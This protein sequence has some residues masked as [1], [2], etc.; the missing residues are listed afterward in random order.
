MPTQPR[1]TAILNHPPN[2]P[3]ECDF[4]AK[5]KLWLFTHDTCHN[6]K[7]RWIKQWIGSKRTTTICAIV[8]TWLSQGSRTLSQCDL[9]R[10]Q[11]PMRALVSFT[12]QRKFLQNATFGLFAAARLFWET[13]WL[14]IRWIDTHA[15]IPLQKCPTLDTDIGT[16][17]QGMKVLFLMPFSTSKATSVWERN[18]LWGGIAFT[19]GVFQLQKHHRQPYTMPHI[20]IATR[21]T[22]QWG[23]CRDSNLQPITGIVMLGLGISLSAISRLNNSWLG[24]CKW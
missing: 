16:F 19:N 14:P 4:T 12:L 1:C 9:T 6:Q 21:P 17:C 24:D 22:N 8:K 13:C 18:L 2:H 20:Y 3:L 10:R 7:L 15:K 5:F 23:S 11:R